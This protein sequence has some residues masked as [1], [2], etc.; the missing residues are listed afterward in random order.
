ME[1]P[2]QTPLMAL[3]AMISCLAKVEKILLMVEKEMMR[4][5]MKILTLQVK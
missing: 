1:H 3:K 2:R 5:K 4:L